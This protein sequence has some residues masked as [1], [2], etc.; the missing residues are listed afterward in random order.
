MKLIGQVKGHISAHGDNI[1]GALFHLFE[2]NLC[3]HNNFAFFNSDEKEHCRTLTFKVVLI[4]FFSNAFSSK[5]R[6]A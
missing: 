5:A 6:I 1:S 3:G 4:E 2:V